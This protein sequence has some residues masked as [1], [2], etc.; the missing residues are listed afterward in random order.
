MAEFSL[1]TRSGQPPLSYHQALSRANKPWPR[2]G[3][4]EAEMGGGTLCPV[5]TPAQPVSAGIADYRPKN[6]EII[7]LRL[8]TW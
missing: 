8:V 7:E 5:N 4:P 6:G 2:G 1:R 3:G